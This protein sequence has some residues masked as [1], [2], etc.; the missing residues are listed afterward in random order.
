MIVISLVLAVGAIVFGFWSYSVSLRSSIRMK[1]YNINSTNREQM[2]QREYNQRLGYA[3]T[4]FV[5]FT[6]LVAAV[7][8]YVF[9][10]S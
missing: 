9:F 5:M 4:L 3:I 10:S 8:Y 2:I 7:V 6:I 1:Y